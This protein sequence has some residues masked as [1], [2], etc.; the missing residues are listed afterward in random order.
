AYFD[1]IYFCPHHPDVGFSGE[2]SS[3][4]LD[5]ECR[6]PKSGMIR[7]AAEFYSID[8]SRSYIVG[9]TWRDIGAGRQAGL[10]ACLGVKKAPGRVGEFQDQKPDELFA[11]LEQA[12]DFVLSEAN[13]SEDGN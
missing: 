4:K 2:N 8:L 1:A 3:Y 11:N 6:K 5:C 9:D 12:V 10:K 13:K 7:A